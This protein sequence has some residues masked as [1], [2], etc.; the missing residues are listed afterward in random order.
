MTLAEYEDLG[1]FDYYV[2]LI[3]ELDLVEAFEDEWDA[4]LEEF[5]LEVSE[6]IVIE[7]TLEA[8]DDTYILTV[9]ERSPA[10]RVLLL[11]E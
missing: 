4:S 7:Q 5:E 1:Q 8:A 2:R 10:Y 6:S 3:R 9:G 11:D